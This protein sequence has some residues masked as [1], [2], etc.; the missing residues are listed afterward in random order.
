MLN[1]IQKDA[2]IEYMNIAIGNAA[3]LLSEM[4]EKKIELSVP[5]IKLIT[6]DNDIN[7]N[8][9]LK[10]FPATGHVVSSSITFRDKLS[11]K[12][13]LIFPAEKSKKLVE[14]CTGSEENGDDEQLSE[15]TDTDFD[16]I[17]ELGNIV[18][19]AVLGGLG[20]LLDVKITYEIPEVEKV[21]LKKLEDNLNQ[22]HNRYLLLLYNDFHIGKKILNGA[23]FI[24]L[25]VNSISFLI[26][27]IDEMVSDIYDE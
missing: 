3:S 12:S 14:L 7:K 23:I 11:G 6:L 2:L 22:S 21:S 16:V 8:K 1:D 20:N 4:T 24:A 17:R 18:L 27:Q 19:N 10:M 9:L 5:E 26:D 13:Q 15:L 25:K